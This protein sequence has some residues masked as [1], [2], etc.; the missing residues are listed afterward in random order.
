MSRAQL[1]EMAKKDL[2]HGRNGTMDKVDEI[3]QVPVENYFD[4]ERWAQE[5]K[6]IFRRMPL[7]LATSAEL[8]EQQQ[9]RH[10]YHLR[11]LRERCDQAHARLGLQSVP[12][13][14]VRIR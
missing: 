12:D 7:L 5:V 3:Y 14:R 6:M 11:V 13:R 4:P 2:A 8:K 10:W 1:I 9:H